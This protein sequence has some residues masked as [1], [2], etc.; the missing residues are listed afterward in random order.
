MSGETRQ[1]IDLK[2]DGEQKLIWLIS[3]IVAMAWIALGLS[4]YFSR[5]LITCL[6]APQELVG[7][8]CEAGMN[9]FAAKG[10]LRHRA[11]M[12]HATFLESEERY[13]ESAGLLQHE[14]ETG[15]NSAPV[16]LRL[17]QARNQNGE[18][19]RAIDAY[20]NYI[21][22]RPEEIDGYTEAASL[23][24]FNK[25]Y[26]EARETINGYI[27]KVPDNALGY[28]W[29]S[30]IER[31]ADKHVQAITAIDQAIKRTPDAPN[32]H[33]D[34]ALSLASLSRWEEALTSHTRAIDI[35]PTGSTFLE[36]RAELFSLLGRHEDAKKD[37]KK[38]IELDRVSST[39]VEL[40]N[41]HR[42]LSDYTAARNALEMALEL[43]PDDVFV[44]GKR[45]E[46][47]LDMQDFDA[48]ARVITA[49]AVS[50]GNS[51]PE[52]VFLRMIVASRQG[53]HL[54]AIKGFKSLLSEWPEWY[55][56]KV[57]IGKNLVEI[58][59]PAAAL[60]WFD[61]A[62]EE[63]KDVSRILSARANAYRALQ[64]WP[65]VMADANLALSLAPGNSEALTQRA[66]A[67][68]ATGDTAGALID[69]RDAVRFEPGNLESRKMLDDLLKETS[70]TTP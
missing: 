20:R 62:L 41:Q 54:E 57:E 40:A 38:S 59:A 42:F 24:V 45:V 37:L 34:R 4:L 70:T 44:Q 68:K 6:Y 22:L 31:S 39:F 21:K 65:R 5:N 7:N 51:D 35:E 1:T 15:F 26:E 63:R 17:A 29:L 11:V 10:P 27:S 58:N 52:T 33:R 9:E 47:Y 64:D 48:A 25:R 55:R 16:I 50:R 53:K 18:T 32:Y 43:S 12:G 36:S 61:K 2:Q 14:V 60:K 8:S 56:L 28:D 19:N 69:L 30:W 67:R 3:A 23:L 13:G 46:L 49:V 66:L